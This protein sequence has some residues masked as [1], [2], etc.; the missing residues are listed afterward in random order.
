MTEPAPV[1]LI[2]GA[3]R[4]IGAAIASRL[5]GRGY[6][7][8][9]H[10]QHSATEAA[11]LC[12]QLNQIR[13]D[14]AHS[15]QANLLDTASVQQ[16]AKDS[17]AR[18]G[19]VNALVNNASSFYPTPLGSATEQQWDELVGSNLKGPY[20]LC[21]ALADELKTRCGSIVNIADIH[22]AQP[23]KN[24][25][26]YC[27]AKAGNKM[28]TKTLAKELAPRVRVNGIAPGVILWPENDNKKG[29]QEKLLKSIPLQRMGSSDDIARL[30][31]FFINNASYITGQTIAVDGGKHLS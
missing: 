12:A 3:A 25:S 26:I 19:Q 27:I 7:V 21:Q 23:L 24:H 11:A 15:L 9:I 16:L 28:L 14:S 13:S 4:R 29:E 1:A 10:Y 8:I 17:V 5:H 30:A 20:F 22:A 6:R 18:W 2:T 31:D